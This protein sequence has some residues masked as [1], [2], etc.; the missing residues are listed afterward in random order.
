ML[1]GLWVLAAVAAV[2]EGVSGLPIPLHE[3]G[4]GPVRPKSTL[5]ADVD[6]AQKYG[7]F[8]WFISHLFLSPPTAPHGRF[9]KNFFVSSV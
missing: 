5:G 2:Q 1:F 8:R 3:I 9:L 7:I 6:L 4:S